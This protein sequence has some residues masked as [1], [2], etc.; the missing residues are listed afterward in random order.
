[1][2][3][4]ELVGFALLSVVALSILR[5]LRPEIAVLLALVAGAVILWRLLPLIERI[6]GL[7]TTLAQRGNVQPIYLD[8]ILRIV[9]IAYI[10]EFGSQI[11]RDAGEGALAAKVELGGKVLILALALP[12]LLAVLQLVVRLIG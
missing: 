11:A 8:T 4:I 1:M 3:A 12:I 2:S 7:L 6:L 9:G 10:V 5:P